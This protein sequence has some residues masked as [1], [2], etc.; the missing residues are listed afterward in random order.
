MV[1]GVLVFR[2]VSSSKRVLTEYIGDP[3]NPDGFKD[4]Y[5]IED[6]KFSAQ[7]DSN[8][9]NEYSFEGFLEV[10]PAWVVWDIKAQSFELQID[11]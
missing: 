11:E 6:I 3:K 8:T 7:S 5:E 4:D 9:L 2:G 1:S 10:P